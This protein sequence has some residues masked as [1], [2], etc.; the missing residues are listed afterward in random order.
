ML[1]VI[2]SLLIA[3]LFLVT[4]AI[5]KAAG[6][7]DREFERMNF[8]EMQ[9]LRESAYSRM[10]LKHGEIIKPKNDEEYYLPYYG[11]SNED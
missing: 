2:I 9:R 5:C 11:I 4:L 3:F 6:N 7:A 10:D 1:W 8:E